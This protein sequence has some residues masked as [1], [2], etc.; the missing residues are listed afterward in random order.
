MLVS[1][2]GFCGLLPYFLFAIPYLLF[3]ICYCDVLIGDTP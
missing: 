1:V 2:A 3:P